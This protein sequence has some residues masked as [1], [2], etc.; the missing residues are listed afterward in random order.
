MAD[1]RSDTEAS[2]TGQEEARIGSSLEGG[3]TKPPGEG[4]RRRH[5][6]FL[7]LGIVLGI[8]V[9]AI[10]FQQ[11]QVSLDEITSETRQ[12]SLARILRALAQP[13]LVTYDTRDSVVETEI[14][15][16]CGPALATSDRIT[17]TPD[18]AAPGETVTVTGSGFDPRQNVEIEFVPDSE[19]AITLRMA[20]V[21]TDADGDFSAEFILPDRES[22][23]PQQLLAVTQEPIGTWRNRVEVYTDAN[24]NGVEDNPI[25]GDNGTHSLILSGEPDVPA[26]ALLDPASEAV[27][28]VTTGES[29]EAVSG[30][31]RGQVAI[32]LAEDTT[33]G[34]RVTSI[35]PGDGGIE[36][37]F[38]GP[39]DTD[40]T[41]WRAALYDGATGEVGTVSPLSDTI[42][43]SPRISD[44]AKITW[45]KILETV[46]LALIATTA[47]VVVSVPLS[48]IAARNIM[49]DISV[50][51]TNLVLILLA[52]PAG[53]V[54]GVLFARL[55]HTVFDPLTT[56][57]AGS[58]P[59]FLVAAGGAWLLIRTAIRPEDVEIPSRA[60]RIK[61]GAML[62]LAGAAGIV[63]LL[64]LA[65]V[66]QQV[67]SALIGAL[68]AVDFLGDFLFGIGEIVDVSLVIIAALATAGVAT[69]L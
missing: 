2:E 44:T 23:Q 31:A 41:N 6:L 32:P 18:C 37:S 26:I 16:P 8:V 56:G 10:A 25:L 33:S 59:V 3:D 36:V 54:V 65:R 50:T 42:Q 48:F 52:I 49:R 34:L 43:L 60:D 66:F 12:Q 30:L 38:E 63:A 1:L 47:G 11:T 13:E 45:D 28:F 20:A 15:V 7:I 4:R 61:K 29:F 62:V 14:G 27:Q 68:G 21:T 22:D 24:E 19:F 67:G 53:L 39:P 51:V 40:M 64:A 17:V 35:E 57:I 9:Y 5:P 69:L 58:L 46:F 55:V